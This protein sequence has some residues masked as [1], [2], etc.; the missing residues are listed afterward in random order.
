MWAILGTILEWLGF[1]LLGAAVVTGA[2]FGAAWFV[3]KE[4]NAG[5]GQGCPCPACQARRQRQ[6]DRRDK[7]AADT[8]PASRINPNL[9]PGQWGKD[10]KMPSTGRWISTME[11]Q[12]NMQVMAGTGAIFRVQAVAPTRY[13]FMVTLVNELTGRTSSIPVQGDGANRPIWLLRIRRG[14]TE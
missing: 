9:P 7:A 10:R 6:L 12:P 8:Q 1:I 11:L 13:G 5:H 3:A 4:I 14:T 2:V